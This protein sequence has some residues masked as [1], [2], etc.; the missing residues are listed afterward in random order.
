M[1]DYIDLRAKR[2]KLIDDMKSLNDKLLSEKR[3]FTPAE[4][5]QY[6]EMDYEV[7]RLSRLIKDEEERNIAAGFSTTLPSPYGEE[8]RVFD[9]TKIFNQ[10][11]FLNIAREQRGV[12]LNG[13][14]AVAQIQELFKEQDNKDSILEKVRYYYG[15]NAMT[16]IPVITSLEEPGDYAEGA[17]NVAT[18]L[19]TNLYV[20]SLKSKA[21]STVLPVTAEMLNLSFVNTKDELQEIFR[22]AFFK[23]IHKGIISGAGTNNKMKGLFTSAA[24]HTA[25]ITRISGSN[26]TLGE[27]ASFALSVAQ[28]DDE[29]TIIMNLATY[30][31]ILAD[32]TSGEDVKLYKECLIRDKSIEG[33]S[34]ILDPYAPS[35]NVAG[36]ILAVAAPL[37]RY[38]VGIAGELMIEPIKEKGDTNTYFQATMFFSGKQV[39]DNDVFSL[40]VA[41]APSTSS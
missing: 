13:S 24:A 28:K 39:T 29:Y 34:I 11:T 41:N 26:I 27:L 37:S 40:A 33:V 12:T 9:G 10:R 25:G 18:D 6:E 38:A 22:K 1:N 5:R 20:T 3:D 19:T 21:Y 14:G 15:A 36:C 32:T 31:K 16:D 23:V 7:N 8:E 17:T 35:T 4:K 30:Q 2:S